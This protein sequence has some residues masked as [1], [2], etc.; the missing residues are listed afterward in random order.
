MPFGG[1]KDQGF[2][3]VPAVGAEVVVMFPMG[4]ERP[5]WIGCLNKKVDNPGPRESTR[6]ADDEHYWQRKEIK[7]RVGWVV[8]DDRDEY[9]NIKHNCGSFISL[10]T[11]GD[12]DIRAERSVNIKAGKSVNIS[13]EKGDFSVE[14]LYSAKLESKTNDF[15]IEAVKG[16]IMIASLKQKID[17]VAG[18]EIHG[19]ADTDIKWY[20]N[21]NIYNTAATE[22]IHNS[23]FK[24]MDTYSK[25]Q[26]RMH[27][28]KEM[29][30]S[31]NENMN[32]S[33]SRDLLIYV[34]KHYKSSVG[35]TGVIKF[36]KSVDVDIET[37][38]LNISTLG[39]MF[40]CH[41]EED[42][43]LDTNNQFVL[44]SEDD[45][46]I[47]TQKNF[48]TYSQNNTDMIARNNMNIGVT[49]DYNLCA[50]NNINIFAASCIDICAIVEIIMRAGM[51]YI[52]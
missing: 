31:S 25:E 2:F 22:S 45:A 15:T 27:C 46:S 8:F 13:A 17:I 4:A 32:I 38:D 41:S 52:N 11:D 44:R 14:A 21:K 19:I 7:T 6:E 29:L 20:A 1:Y 18:T 16:K 30:I 28:D 39:G 34:V 36:G 26:L 33:S 3:F 42:M 12:I 48:N 40:K 49:R 5:L 47:R 9:I 10:K 50:Y 37:G 51:I 24:N 23:A 35:Q 43:Q